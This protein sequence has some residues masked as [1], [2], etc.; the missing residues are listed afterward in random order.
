MNTKRIQTIIIISLLIFIGHNLYKNDTCTWTD[1]TAS[2][3]NN[4]RMATKQFLKAVQGDTTP[5]K[6]RVIN[7]LL[8]DGKIG[9]RKRYVK[10]L[11]GM[12]D[13][14]V[15]DVVS[16]F[17][18]K[19][20]EFLNGEAKR[21]FLW[22]DPELVKDSI[23]PVQSM[24]HH[25]TEMGFKEDSGKKVALASFPGSGSTWSRTLLEDATGVFTGAIYCDKKLKGSG[26]V[27][28]YIT[29]GNVI[30]IKT[31]QHLMNISN[32]D[33]K[34]TIAFDAAIFIIRNVFDAVISERKRSVSKN[35]TGGE[36]K[37]ED[38]GMYNCVKT[39][40]FS[41]VCSNLL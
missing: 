13:I 26:F 7:P 15:N 11:E 8:R 24:S 17:N 19:G 18:V 33:H 12:S 22:C 21:D 34:H 4:H 10:V 37:E 30:A 31:H 36:M 9:T 38:Y 23:Q 5:T 3:I 39:I 14:Q 40:I 32:P 27:G 1:R 20:M 2:L 6:Y 28:E 41:S 35:H 25:C 16:E 29:T